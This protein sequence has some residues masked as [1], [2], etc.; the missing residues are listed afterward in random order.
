MPARITTFSASLLEGLRNFALQAFER[1]FERLTNDQKSE[2]LGKFFLREV[3][4][5]SVDDLDWDEINENWLDVSN[6]KGTD[7][8]FRANNQVILLQSKYRKPTATIQRSELEQTRNVLRVLKHLKDTDLPELLA[9]TS[10]IDW[11]HDTFRIFFLCSCPVS[12]RLKDDFASPRSD[13]LEANAHFEVVDLTE[14]EKQYDLALGS[15][16]SLPASVR[17]QLIGNDDAPNFAL[18]KEPRTTYFFVTP[19]ASLVDAYK[20]HEQALFHYNVRFSLGSTKVNKGIIKTAK[21]RPSYFVS[22]NNGVSAI[23]E[24]AALV[25]NNTAIEGARLQVING[26]QT[27]SSLADPSIPSANLWKI[28]VAVKLTVVDNLVNPAPDERAFIEGIVRCNNTQNPTKFAD[29]RS[30]DPFHVSLQEFFAREKF[31][32]KSVEYRPKRIRK[33]ASKEKTIYKIYL[34]DFC[35]TLYSFLHNPVQFTSDSSFL[36]SIESKD[37]GYVRLF[38]D[39]NGALLKRLPTSLC[40]TYAAIWWIC[41]YARVEL[42]ADRKKYRQSDKLQDKEDH[43]ALERAYFVFSAMRILMER[44]GTIG[45]LPIYASPKWREIDN[46]KQLKK[47]KA[48][49][50]KAKWVVI[51]SHR[52]ALKNTQS[53]RSW[54]SSTDTLESIARH[55]E[56]VPDEV[57]PEL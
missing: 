15:V 49:Y 4:G 37:T 9:R 54:L 41:D 33:P 19:A 56:L 25:E 10:D 13:P 36:F 28:E 7:F 3:L 51:G 32:G 52:E 31:R 34:E 6:D 38:G 21:N 43:Q 57:L 45:K 40:Q 30:R 27:V 2:A 8:L 16:S 1:E 35:K 11:K 50:D 5:P 55:S 20:K 23:A 53:H 47:I 42:V 39:V 46:G 24:S 17:L 44:R 29:T 26:A 22:Y 14:L 18:T 12:Q 48:Y